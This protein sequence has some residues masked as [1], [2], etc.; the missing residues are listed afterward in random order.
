MEMSRELRHVIDVA[1]FAPIG[2]AVIAH[3][4]LPTLIS[5]GREHVNNR[6]AV[7]R[8]L[9]TMAVQ[10]GRAEFDRRMH[11]PTAAEPA[12]A[13]TAPASP[14][15]DA[16]SAEAEPS[17]TSASDEG[18]PIEGYDSLAASQVVVRLSSL[19]NVELEQIRVHEAA[20]R[21]RRTVLGKIAQ[22][23]ES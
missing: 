18:L 19:T 9:G 11:A 4:Q 10:R 13:S 2:L 7:A 20:H 8:F 16:P 12:T 23:Q 15:A 6:L 22:L 1:V 21:A 3:E 14:V 5:S 17:R